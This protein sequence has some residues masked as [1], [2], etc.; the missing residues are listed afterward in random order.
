MHNLEGESVSNWNKTRN[1]MWCEA[2][3]H[4]DD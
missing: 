3:N 1:K 4:T 2:D